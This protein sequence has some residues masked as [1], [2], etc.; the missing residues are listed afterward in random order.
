MLASSSSPWKK[1]IDPP[2]SPAMRH[3]ARMVRLSSP[4]L[5]LG[6]AV[7]VSACGGEAALPSAASLDDVV[8]RLQAAGLT[9]HVT[10]TG[11]P[12]GTDTASCADSSDEPRIIPCPPGSPQTAQCTDEVPELLVSF[13]RPVPRAAGTGSL[14]VFRADDRYVYGKNF[15][16][17]TPP[18]LVDRV[19]K[20]TGGRVRTAGSS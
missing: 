2:A 9:C 18:A 10:R 1:R 13:Y 5:A 15:T 7:V 20:A 17:N 14:S 8:T 6:L 16:I 4:L 3:H 12:S 19:R 11:D